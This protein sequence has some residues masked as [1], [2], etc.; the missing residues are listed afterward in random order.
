[1][2]FSDGYL[3]CV[4]DGTNHGAMARMTPKGSRMIMAPTSGS[5]A[6]GMMPFRLLR[7]PATSSTRSR[8]TSRL[9]SAHCLGQP[10]SSIMNWPSSSFLRWRISAALS[11][12]PRRCLGSV[13]FHVL[14]AWAAESTAAWTSVSEALPLRW[15]T[16]PVAGD[17]TSKLLDGWTSSPLMKKGTE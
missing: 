7:R 2:G 9:K 14:K 17:V 4:G 6:V 5:A 1:M 16:L 3:G 12:M 11:R 8:V 13:F 15:T 10:V